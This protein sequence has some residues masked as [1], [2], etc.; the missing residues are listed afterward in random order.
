MQKL[1]TG[2]TRSRV[3]AH[4]L[5]T[6]AVAALIAAV[7]AVGGAIPLTAPAMAASVRVATDAANGTTANGEATSS[8]ATS[9]TAANGTD[10]NA[11]GETADR[12]ADAA[13]SARL[14]VAVAEPADQKAAGVQSGALASYDVQW[15]CAGVQGQCENTTLSVT[16]PGLV[17]SVSDADKLPLTHVTATNS[18][19]D[20]AALPVREGDTYTWNLGTVP[21]GTTGAMRVQV[22]PENL[23][24]PEGE[25]IRPKV[26]GET[27]GQVADP[28]ELATPVHAKPSIAVRKFAPESRPA[29]GGQYTYTITA[30]YEGA[31]NTNENK[32]KDPGTGVPGLMGLTEI[33]LVDTLPEGAEF[34]RATDGGTYDPAT[35]TV[36]WVVPGSPIVHAVADYRVTVVFPTGTF[37]EGASATNTVNA[38]GTPLD[39]KL[40]PVTATDSVTRQLQNL[41]A[42]GNF[43]K[44]ANKAVTQRGGEAVWNISWSNTGNVPLRMHVADNLPCRYISPEAPGACATPALRN[45]TAGLVRPLLKKVPAKVTYTTTSGKELSVAVDP[46]TTRDFPLTVPAGE[47]ITSIA[48]DADVMNGERSDITLAIR[49]TVA[50]DFPADVHNGTTAPDG[51]TYSYTPRYEVPTLENRAV[52]TAQSL[53]F[54]GNPTPE[55]PANITTR[56]SVAQ[57][58]I[59]DGYPTYGVSKTSHLGGQMVGNLDTKPGELFQTGQTYTF[60]LGFYTGKGAKFYPV[61]MDLLAPGMEYDPK[62]QVTTSANWPASLPLD[63]MRVETEMK[64]VDGKQRQLVRFTWPEDGTGDY[65]AP[66]STGDQSSSNSSEMVLYFGAKITAATEPGENTNDM[67]L[68]DAKRPNLG[69]ATAPNQCI[70]NWW[71]RTDSRKLTDNLD[72][73][74]RPEARGC[75]TSTKFNVAGLPALAGKNYVK[76]DVDTEFQANPNYGTVSPS[77]AAELKLD[78]VNNGNTGVSGV[79]VYDVL[80]YPGDHGVSGAN[81]PEN[82]R[83][84]T[85]RPRLNGPLTFGEG[86]PQPTSVLYS[87]SV[88]PCRGEVIT[89]GGAPKS[90]PQNCETGTWKTAEQLGGD[91]SQVRAF[92]V[93]FPED[94]KL[95]RADTWTISAN[96]TAPAAARGIAWNSYAVTGKNAETGAPVMPTEPAKVGLTMPF[97]LDLTKENIHA[98]SADLS[99]LSEKATADPTHAG[100]AEGVALADLEK[101]NETDRWAT[102]SVV[103]YVVR[104]KNAG[105]GFATGVE[106]TDM[107]PK[108]V[109]YV[110]YWSTNGVY[111]AATGTWRVNDTVTDVI[112]PSTGDP[113]EGADP[114]AT[115]D[116]YLRF[117]HERGIAPGSEEVL[118]LFAVVDETARSQQVCNE[119]LTPAAD[120]LDSKGAKFAGAQANACLTVGVDLGDRIWEDTNNN[121]VDDPGEPGLA[122]VTVKVFRP[123]DTEPFITT[124]TDASGKY[125]VRGLEPGTY[126]VVVD[127]ATLPKREGT[128][129]T[130]HVR[131]GSGDK[132]K[133]SSGEITLSTADVLD[134]D[135]GFHYVAPVPP[136]PP[137]PPVPP[138]PPVPPAPEPTV[139]EPTTP[140]PTTPAPQPTGDRVAPE[141]SRTPDPRPTTTAPAPQPEPTTPE[142]T[143]TTT[144]PAPEPTAP[145]PTTPEPTVPA[146]TTPAPTSPAPS[147]PVPT[148]STTVPAPQPSA[149]TDGPAASST[150]SANPTLSAS[151]NPSETPASPAPAGPGPRLPRT[152]AGVLGAAGAVL[153]LL[154]GGV[155]ALRRRGE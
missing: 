17:D 146:P 113:V 103:E 91:F 128:W 58:A 21:V 5:I 112:D 125:L 51:A 117:T 147:T 19:H 97:D 102:G 119:A 68:A 34:V 65:F 24:W 74:N 69:T 107:L 9:S 115:D 39:P 137:Q 38:T 2:A 82:K 133:A 127:R 86:T 37:A 131:E 10:T 148:A 62:Q 28:V 92:R 4:R 45:V 50:D 66:P 130:T 22:R 151:G 42:E 60:G 23:R 87:T 57:V 90:G 59:V 20:Q 29:I 31:F 110:G 49:G 129:E 43:R 44:T 122:G 70:R 18:S 71:A 134:A 101:K 105:P 77:S 8:T 99:V 67:I 145:A 41:R 40:A 75:T 98:K 140:A 47:E 61:I 3:A 84:S 118:H 111:D 26:A 141:P 81:T 11:A 139:P 155:L 94:S 150:P 124:T 109:T 152:G 13:S 154:A 136:V 121:G 132:E 36:T 83:E 54:A 12:A 144:V 48:L 153:A 16:I 142:P 53:D 55:L 7:V 32:F 63:K 1:R 106:I 35:R 89:L 120:R 33:R 108:G 64:T 72:G 85:W 114:N 56:E 135:F 14:E 46:T 25:A 80:P 100:L 88:N 95:T 15:S 104:A 79:V 76:G 126:S 52:V 6:G 73:L 78:L 96:V 27:N 143:A 30:G 123:G 149:S 116:A 93:E 138:E